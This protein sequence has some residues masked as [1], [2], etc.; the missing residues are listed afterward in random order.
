MSDLPPEP[1]RP[2]GDPIPLDQLMKLAEFTQRDLDQAVARADRR[3]RA[4]ATAKTRE[5]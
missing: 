2:I 5:R 3:L 4:F 1:V